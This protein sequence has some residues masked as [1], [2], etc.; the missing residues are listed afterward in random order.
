MF[1]RKGFVEAQNIAGLEEG[2]HAEAPEKKIRRLAAFD[3]T[4]AVRRGGHTAQKKKETA[5]SCGWQSEKVV[6]VRRK[7]E[8]R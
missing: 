4:I 1:V 5:R 7:A 3:G 6:R 8:R 2:E